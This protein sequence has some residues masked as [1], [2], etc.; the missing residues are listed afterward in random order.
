MSAAVALRPCSRERRDMLGNSRM[1]DMKHSFN[2]KSMALDH[3][4]R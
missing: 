3:L 2:D 4:S 1:E